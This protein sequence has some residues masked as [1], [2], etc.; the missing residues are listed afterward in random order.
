[1]EDFKV[2]H[3]DGQ[4]VSAPEPAEVQNEPVENTDNGTEIQKE[5]LVEE[6]TVQP[7]QPEST[8]T[9]TQGGVGQEGEAS[10]EVREGT[11]GEQ[12]QEV[13]QPIFETTTVNFGEPEPEKEAASVEFDQP[14]G[15]DLLQFLNENNDLINSYNQLNQN[16][17]EMDENALIEA[18]L[19]DKHSNLSQDDINSLLERYTYDEELDER[20]DIVSKKIAKGDALEAAKQYLTSKKDQL[21]QELASRNLGGPSQ[22]EVEAQQAQQA[23]VNHFN[24]STQNFFKNDLE[25]F[26]FQL[27]DDKALNLK[28]NDKEAVLKNQASIETLL[29][30]YFDENTGQITDAAGYHRAIFAAM[31]IDAITRNAYEQGKADAITTVERDAKNIDMDGRKTHAETP[32]QGTQWKFI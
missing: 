27:N 14:K 7:Q 23:A 3:I 16:F 32:V 8:E 21:H 10:Q 19:K 26:Q 9:D 4:D 17:D 25:A 29:N 18:H 12:R 20:S 6:Q 30:P 31:N 2:T 13:E 28:I 15:V 24:E 5:Q 1:M 11:Q 22:A